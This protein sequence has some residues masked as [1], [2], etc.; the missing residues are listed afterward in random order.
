M[1]VPKELLDI[2][3]CPLCRTE[4]RPT[5]DGDGLKCVRCGRVYPVKDDIPVMLPEEAKEEAPTDA[6]QFT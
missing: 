3:A 6:G 4:V 2:L 1:S 5:P